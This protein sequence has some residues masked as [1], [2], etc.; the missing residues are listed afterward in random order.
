MSPVLQT[1]RYEII[2]AQNSFHGRTMATLSATGQDKIKHSFDPLL[3]EL[4]S[5][6]ATGSAACAGRYPPCSSAGPRRKSGP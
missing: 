5:E 6:A 3:P 2:T 1:G 4:P